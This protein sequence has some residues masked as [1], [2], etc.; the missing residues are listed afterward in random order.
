MVRAISFGSRG[1]LSR[2]L[3]E[4]KLLRRVEFPVFVELAHSTKVQALH[5]WHLDSPVGKGEVRI[6]KM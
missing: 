4:A 5:A 6:A 1:C 3:R 2:K